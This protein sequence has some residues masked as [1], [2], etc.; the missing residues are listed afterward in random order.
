MGDLM[1]ALVFGLWA[2]LGGAVIALIVIV[3]Q[4]LASVF[5]VWVYAFPIASLV[6]VVTVFFKLRREVKEYQGKLQ[7]DMFFIRVTRLCTR[8]IRE[9]L[10]YQ[11]R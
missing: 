6:V 8:F 5:G 1:L 4:F 7:Q 9:I 11:W 3:F 2:L 10:T